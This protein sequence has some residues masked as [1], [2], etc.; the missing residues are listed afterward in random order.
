MRE[1]ESGSRR[2]DPKMSPAKRRVLEMSLIVGRNVRRRADD[3][4]AESL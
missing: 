2:T 4:A 1:V 3:A